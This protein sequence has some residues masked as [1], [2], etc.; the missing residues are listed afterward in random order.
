LLLLVEG[1]DLLK[2]VAVGRVDFYQGHQLFYRLVLGIQLQLALAG[3]IL[4][5][6]TLYLVLLLRQLAAVAAVM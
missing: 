5:G 1:L 6:Q 2:V 4:M 3:L